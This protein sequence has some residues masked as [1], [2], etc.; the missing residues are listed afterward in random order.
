MRGVLETLA[1]KAHQGAT[2][3]DRHRRYRRGYLGRLPAAVELQTQTPDPKL[4][5]DYLRDRAGLLYPRGVG[6]YTFPHRNFQEYLAACYLTDDDYPERLARSTLAEPN[7]LA[8]GGVAGG[9]QGRPGS[10]SESIGN[11]WTNSA[12]TNRV[13]LKLN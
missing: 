1:F 12:A 3:P 2:G 5:V 7:R 10:S 8:R 9:G 6:I 4:L 11:W 13:M